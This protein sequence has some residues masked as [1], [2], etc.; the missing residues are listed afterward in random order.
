MVDMFLGAIG[1]RPTD[2]R[3]APYALTKTLPPRAVDLSQPRLLSRWQGRDVR[4]PIGNQGGMGSCAAFSS[5]YAVMM[6]GS[7]SGRTIE[8]IAPGPLYEQA[9]RKQGWFP[10][11]TGSYIADNLDLLLDGGPAEIQPYV[12]DGSF[13]YDEAA[14]L[15]KAARD[16]EGSHRPFYPA[17]GQFA[18]NVWSA[19]DAGMP[20]VFGSY[21]PSAWFNPVGGVVDANPAWN[22]RETG[23]HAY[24]VWGI[25]SGLFFCGNSWSVGWSPDAGR[26]GHDCRPGDFAIP[27]A[28]ASNG[29]IFEAR[30]VAYEKVPEPPKPDPKPP[31]DLAYKLYEAAHRAGDPIRDLERQHPGNEEY[32]Y[33]RLGADE[34]RDRVSEIYE[35]AR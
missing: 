20:I 26:A 11:D 1:P 4:L 29:I 19:L 6:A 18:E 17:E 23:A 32:H 5:A 10:G 30:A 21:W 7:I 9:R 33:R 8:R 12:A 28:A 3:E 35:A 13:D 34:V 16:Y 22:P 31:V 27:F 2:P 25:G 15:G 24:Y 14:W